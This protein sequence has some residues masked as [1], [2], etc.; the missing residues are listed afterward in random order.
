MDTLT[1]EQEIRLVIKAK[2][3]CQSSMQTLLQAYSPAIKAA[4]HKVSEFYDKDDAR[5]EA[6]LTFI[7]LVNSHDSL[8]GRLAG[9]IKAQLGHSLRE[10]SMVSQQSWNIPPRT[11]RRF[12]SILRKAD[13]DPAAGAEM[14]ESFGMAKTTF[15]Q[16]YNLLRETTNLDA[17]VHTN[18]QPV[19]SA[20]IIDLDSA[21]LVETARGVL[22]D[23]QRRI[24]DCYYGFRTYDPMTDAETADVLGMNKGTVLKER[25]K[26]LA[27]MRNALCVV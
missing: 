16:I 25:H 22:G 18:A 24:V 27:K 15:N 2:A 23:E 7:S 21:I 19:H 17:T 11:Q 13:H 5:Q 12:L 20:H 26:A 1:E 3:G 10:A 4:V 6:Y 14:A 9:R 8:K